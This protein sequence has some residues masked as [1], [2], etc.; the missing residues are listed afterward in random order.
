MESVPEDRLDF[1]NVVEFAQFC[2]ERRNELLSS[3]KMEI[4]EF[5]EYFG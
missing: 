5:L 4:P 1:W 2:V 3:G